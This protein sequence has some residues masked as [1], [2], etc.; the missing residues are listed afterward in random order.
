[1][2]KEAQHKTGAELKVRSIFP[3]LLIRAMLSGVRVCFFNAVGN[4]WWILEGKDYQRRRKS[5][6]RFPASRE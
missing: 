5:E 2:K 4:S 6:Y 3:D 1:L